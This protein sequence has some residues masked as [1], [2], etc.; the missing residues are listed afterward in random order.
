MNRLK[1]YVNIVATAVAEGLSRLTK[2]LNSQKHN[3]NDDDEYLAAG[4]YDKFGNSCTEAL[5]EA[6][7]AK[8]EAEV[9]DLSSNCWYQSG[10]LGK[11]SLEM[12]KHQS[13]G[14]FV[15][16]KGSFKSKNFILSLRVPSSKSAKVKHF[17]VLQSRKG[18]RLKGATKFFPTIAALV[19]HHSVMAEQLPVTLAVQRISSQAK[20]D[21]DFG[22]VD[23]LKVNFSDLEDV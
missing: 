8:C 4:I 14:S 7:T 16:H 11:F 19:T 6:P 21:D 20:N 18:Y 15:I 12:L 9:E 10:L 2:L 23:E 17:L 13:S 5:R 1:W 22:S 3:D